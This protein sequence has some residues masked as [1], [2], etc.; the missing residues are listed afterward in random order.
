MHQCLLVGDDV[1]R[2]L[3]R[4]IIV[5]M[6]VGLEVCW[7]SLVL[8]LVLLEVLECLQHYICGHSAIF[9][10]DDVCVWGVAYLHVHVF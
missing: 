6:C 5:S 10:V 1:R 4:Y 3:D 2:C 8:V 7:S 9:V